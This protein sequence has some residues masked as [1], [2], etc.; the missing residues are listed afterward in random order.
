MEPRRTSPLKGLLD[1]VLA[2]VDGREA[3]RPILLV[4]GIGSGKTATGLR[5]LSLLR[6]S[7]IRVGG[8]LA[9]RIM[10]EDE[11]I[12]YSLIDLATNTTH[13]F[14]GLEPS[15]VA[16]GRFFISSESLAV[17]E[18]AATAALDAAS[19]VMIDE[20]GRLEVGGGGHAPA[21]RRLL[22]SNVVPI[23][24]VRDEL[25]DDV[26]AAF[27]IVD[28]TIFH[29][30]DALDESVASPAGI[31]TFWEIVDSLP[32]PLLVTV[33]DDGY[34]QS[35]PMH[36]V[37]R[38]ANRLWFATSRASRKVAQIGADPRVTVLFVDSSRFNYAAIH[39]LA[40]VVVDPER[41]KTLWQDEWRDDWP[42]GPADP[43]YVLLR[44]DGVR[45]H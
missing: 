29:A 28:P 35:R 11:T 19:V 18:R 17:A 41:E 45:G 39:G 7:G 30:R 9:P 2:Q 43:D 13:P 20:V 42:E 38:D 33:G 44:I 40:H 21:V 34:P 3:V 5:L 27:G 37:D 6:Q 31:R 15:D 10:E 16:V 24:L 14:A 23:L 12:G 25:V 26:S 36:L 1:Q 22:S 4:G 8:F 32:Y